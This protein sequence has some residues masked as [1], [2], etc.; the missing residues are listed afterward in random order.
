MPPS[1]PGTRC[2]RVF[3]P[4]R[5]A[6]ERRFQDDGSVRTQV[7]RQPAVSTVGNPEVQLVSI[8][9]FAHE[10]V[11][12]LRLA[13]EQGATTIV[14]TSDELCNS[15]RKAGRWTEACCEAMQAELEPGDDVLSEQGRGSRMTVRLPRQ[16]KPR[17]MGINGR[18][19]QESG[20]GELEHLA[21]ILSPDLEE[22]NSRIC[23]L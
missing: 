12:Q 19:T 2:D 8:D 9:H 6:K 4:L 1:I 17:P 13:S 10:L 22:T 3:R 16:Q 14:I 20:S 7:N 23:V 21:K 11:W 18:T 5:R 15:I